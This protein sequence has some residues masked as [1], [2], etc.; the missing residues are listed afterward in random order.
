[1]RFDYFR[2]VEILSKINRYLLLLALLFLFTLL[3]G[4]IQGFQRQT[5]SLLFQL[6]YG[7]LLG[8][9]STSTTLLLARGFGM[10]VFGERRLR[11]FL[12]PIL[13]ILLLGVGLFVLNLLTGFLK[14]R[15]PYI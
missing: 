3:I 10:V 13:T 14:I 7:A 9:L 11:C 5:H 2:F 4:N 8:S 12:S 1:M 15:V 6:L